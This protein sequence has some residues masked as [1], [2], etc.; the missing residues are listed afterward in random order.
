[1]KGTLDDRPGIFIRDEPI[2]SSERSINGGVQ[3]K[4]KKSGVVRL[5]GL[6]AKTN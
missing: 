6:D 3:L 5:K 2:F 1:V 4:K